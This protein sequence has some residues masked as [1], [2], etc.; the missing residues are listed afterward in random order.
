MALSGLLAQAVPNTA[1]DYGTELAKQQLAQQM[2]AAQIQTQQI[3]QQSAQDELASKRRAMA[4]SMLNGIANE[5]DPQKQQSLYATL[6]PMAERYDTTLK[7]PDAYDPTL[8][9]ALVASQISPKD[10]LAQQVELEK[11]RILANGRS[12]VVGK[13]A[14]GNPI[15]IDKRT[16]EASPVGAG[17]DSPTGQ[18][19]APPRA[20]FGFDL[21]GVNPMQIKKQTEIDAKRMEAFNNN[22][23]IIENALRSLDTI[24]PNLQN[25]QTGSAGDLRLMGDKAA[26]MFLP[27]SLGASFQKSADAGNNIDKATND[28]VTE[29]QKFQYVPGNRGSVLGLK[30]MLASKPGVGQQEQTNRNIISGLRTKLTDHQLSEELAQAYQEANPLKVIDSNADKL[31]DALKAVYPLES[32]D[33]ETGAVTFHPESV[34]RIR[35]AIPEAIGNPQKYFDLARKAKGGAAGE[36]RAKL[37]APKPTGTPVVRTQAEF[38]ALPSGSVY[39]EIGDD[40]K[41]QS[42]RKP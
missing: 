1:A 18:P 31:D 23:P 22:R 8:A 4:V 17:T 3:Q 34:D 20:A 11:A 36:A 27:G 29:L 35:D 30:T 19:P 40:G 13:D 6:K 9:R 32:V 15:L 10:Q 24:E 25:F 28:L 39:V 41:P 2:G 7:L 26:A 38:D 33:P 37:A 12:L 16:N 21:A 14:L 42:Y 5:T